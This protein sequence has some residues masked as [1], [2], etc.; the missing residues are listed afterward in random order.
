MK[1]IADENIPY[2]ER[3]FSQIGEVTLLPGR[4]MQSQ[5]L[6]CADILLVRSVTK[7]NASLL[8]GHDIKFVGTCTIGTDHIDNEY[9][10]EQ[11]IAF[12]S[13]P[14]CN[15]YGVVQYDLC[16][17]GYL[18]MLD[19][20]LRYAVVG[21]GNVGGRVYR[22]LKA[23]GFDCIGI[24]PHLDKSDIPDLQSFDKIFDCDVICMHTPLIKD[25]PYP[26]ESLIGYEELTR[27][28]SGAVLLNAGRGEC[29]DNDALLRYLSK[30]NDLSVVLDVWASEPNMNADLF[31]YVKIGTPHIA[32][33]S[34]EGRVNGSTMIFE[35][36]CRHLGKPQ[37]WVNDALKALRDEAFGPM[38]A[39]SAS[40]LNEL[41]AAT[42][43]I[44]ADHRDLSVA[45]NTLPASFDA[46][47]K[48]YFKRREFTH[49]R[50]DPI[51]RSQNSSVNYCDALGFGGVSELGDK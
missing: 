23:L 16:A 15:A 14:G 4:H 10:A 44:E 19:A 31:P 35:A 49:Y 24:D 47:R 38:E 11:G 51:Y 5:D 33:Y 21:C 43:E 3:L 7:V 6:D 34:F 39:V 18:G 27:L 46:L 26:T 41:V 37:V 17:L 32:G 36:L 42:Y 48:Q 8:G 20:S 28:K 12:S 45:L 50:C 40:N 9:L 2:A 25:G 13:A 1:I 22:H 30:H 29:I